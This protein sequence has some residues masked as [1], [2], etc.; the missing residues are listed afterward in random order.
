MTVR[1]G[2]VGQCLE[3]NNATTYGAEGNDADHEAMLSVGNEL[4]AIKSDWCYSRKRRPLPQRFFSK[5]EIQSR[6]TAEITRKT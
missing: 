2:A 3:T 5:L 1:S 6:A 4:E